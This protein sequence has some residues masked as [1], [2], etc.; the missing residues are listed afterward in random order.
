VIVSLC[1]AVQTSQALLTVYDKRTLRQ[2]NHATHSSSCGCCT[3]QYAVAQDVTNSSGCQVIA[4]DVASFESDV[5]RVDKR[6]HW[7]LLYLG[8]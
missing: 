5:I 3:W 2:L 6:H 1:A 4:V 7:P 8:H